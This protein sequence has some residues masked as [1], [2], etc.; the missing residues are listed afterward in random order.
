MDCPVPEDMDGRVLTETLRYQTL[1][2]R[3]EM[4]EGIESYVNPLPDPRLL[5]QKQEK[6]LEHRLRGL[7]YL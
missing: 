4:A 1:G 6:E 2:H 5:S 7:G 3:I